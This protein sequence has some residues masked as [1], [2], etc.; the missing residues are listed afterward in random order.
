MLGTTAGTMLVFVSG[1]VMAWPLGDLYFGPQL[2]AIS[3]RSPLALAETPD[4]GERRARD[5]LR[6]G[7]ALRLASFAGAG[8]AFEAAAVRDARPCVYITLR[9]ASSSHDLLFCLV[10]SIYS[11]D[12]LGAVGILAQSMGVWWIVIFDIIV[13]NDP[14][15]TRGVNFSILLQHLRRGLTCATPEKRPVVVVD[16]AA[17]ALATA[18]A[19]HDGSHEALALHGMIRKLFAWLCAMALDDRYADVV[20]CS[21]PVAAAPKPPPR[22]WRP[23]DDVFEPKFPTAAEFARALGPWLQ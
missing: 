17:A 10:G 13:G 9:E 11:Y 21:G 15:H 3:S 20:I 5:A 12:R 2:S 19:C 8:R 4:A 22:L 14:S 7:A 16:H 23:R 6:E 1:S 18:K